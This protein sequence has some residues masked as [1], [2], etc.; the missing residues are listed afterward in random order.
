MSLFDWVIVEKNFGDSPTSKYSLWT[1]ISPNICLAIY[2]GRFREDKLHKAA[3]G[4]M[5]GCYWEHDGE[6]IGNLRNQEIQQLPHPPL[7]RKKIGGLECILARLIG[8]QE[9]LCLLVFFIIFGLGY[10]QGHNCGYLC[11]LYWFSCVHV[12]KV[13]FII[14]VMGLFDQTITKEITHT[15]MENSKIEDF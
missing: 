5:W 11:Y 14:L 7:K 3:Y 13:N 6:H 1:N 4:A 9:I 10:W 2:L 8:C 12:C 15:S